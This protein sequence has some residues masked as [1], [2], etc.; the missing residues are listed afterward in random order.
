MALLPLLT[1]RVPVELVER[2]RRRGRGQLQPGPLTEPRLAGLHRAVRVAL[3]AHN[4]TQAQWTEQVDLVCRLEDDE[5][6]RESSERRYRRGPV[7]PP[8]PALARLL[9]SP[10]WEWELR[11]RL[12]PRLYQ[13]AAITAAA[14]SVMLT[15]SEVTFFSS[16]PTLSLFALFIQAGAGNQDYRWVEII[17]FITIC[18]MCLC[19]YYTVFRVRV[20]NYYY[21]AGNHQSDPTTL[22]FSGALLSRLTPPLCLNFLSM[23]HMDVVSIVQDGFNLYFPVLLLLLTTATYFSLGS[24][25]LSVLG[26]QQ[27]LEQAETTGELVEEGKELARREKR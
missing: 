10:G 7:S 1:N 22:L 13:A 27:F 6:N 15:W 23:G 2:A 5:R 26:F 19:A 8:P 14:M 3:S 9:L 25:L 21:L 4:R 18:Y 11:C 16:S 24:R 20:L 12:L 17:S